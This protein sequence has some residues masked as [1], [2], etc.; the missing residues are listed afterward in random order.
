MHNAPM[1]AKTWYDSQSECVRTKL[2]C[3]V[4]SL[5]TN[6]YL[7]HLATRSTATWHTRFP[8]NRLQGA[9]PPP[10][11]SLH[12]DAADASLVD[13]ATGQ[14]VHARVAAGCG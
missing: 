8:S 2:T 1:Q 14:L 9:L 5:P 3:P 6:P 10:F 11:L 4:M 13:Q 7:A 12:L